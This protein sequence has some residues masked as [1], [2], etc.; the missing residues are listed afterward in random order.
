[1]PD[2]H[3][4]TVVRRFCDSFAEGD[5]DAVVDFFADDGVYHNMQST[6]V[7]GRDAIRT[8][9]GSYLLGN[10]V[11]FEVVNIASA[12][13]LVFAERIDHVTFGGEGP[14]IDLPLVGVFEVT[15]D[16]HLAAWRDYFD[17]QQFTSQLPG[18]APTT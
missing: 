10:R 17:L 5:L 11:E 18:A 7:V 8:A 13:R 6:P 16:G 9:I 1:M 4:R 14:T 12:G 2:M 3:P 15:A